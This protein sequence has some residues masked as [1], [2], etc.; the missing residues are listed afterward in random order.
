MPELPD[1]LA[2]RL[3]KKYNINDEDIS[4]LISDKNIASFYE[5]TLKYID[6]PA[7]VLNW[8]RVNV[9]MVINRDKINIIDFIVTPKRLSELLDLLNQGKITKENANRIFEVMISDNRSASKIMI[10]SNLEIS[11][12]E[13]ELYDI[14]NE[15]IHKFPNE[16]ERLHNGEEKLIK[17]FMGQIMRETKG[18]YPADLI[19]R[20]LKKIK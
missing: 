5:D 2:S 12:N 6:E 4:F 9:M 14:I 18:K 8:I 1:K 13:D 19:I 3:K 7:L 20:E 10:E 16:L 15:I 17:F 11:T